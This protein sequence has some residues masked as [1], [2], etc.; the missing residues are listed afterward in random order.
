MT[1]SS[2]FLRRSAL[3]ALLSMGVVALQPAQA[4]SVWIDAQNEAVR[5]IAAAEVITDR[6]I[7][8]YRSGA[9]ADSA[10]A[11]MAVRVAGNRQGV[12]VAL[13]RHTASGARVMRLNRVLR[14]TELEA[15]AR[16]LR[17][18]DSGIEYAEPDVLLK[19]A[20]TPNDPQWVQQWHLGTE[21]AGI[22]VATAWDKAQGSGVTVAV[23]D[24]GVRPHAD[25]AA[26]LLPGY[27]FVTDLKMAGDGN[28]RDADATD[29]GDFTAAGQCGSGVAAESSSWHGTHVAGIVGART[30]N[31]VGVAG[32]APLIRVLPVR[33]LGRC[34]GYTSDIA[35][36]IIWAVGGSVPGAPINANPARVI[37][38]SLGGPGTCALTTQNA[39][40]TARSKGAVVVVAAG[41]SR[42][43]AT[44]TQPANCSGVITVAATN[45]AGGRASYSNFGTKVT[46][47]APGG[48]SDGQ[49]LS[50]YNTGSTTPGTDSYAGLSGTSMAAPVVSGVVA[51]MLSANKA[52]TPDQVAS[53]LKS[54]SRAFP[55]PCSGCGAGLVDATAAVAAAFGQS[56]APAPASTPTP[57]PAP[58]PTPA[59]APAP[60]P[61]TGTVTEKESN[62]TV[63]TAQVLPDG[64]KLVNGSLSTTSDVDHFRFTVPAGKTVAFKLTAGSRS[65]FG[66]GLYLSSGQLLSQVSA[67]VG[68]VS[69]LS[70]RNAG[71][72]PLAIVV[73]VRRTAGEA[74]AY[75]LALQ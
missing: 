57:A 48:D 10:R 61:T 43:D 5:P 36:A 63:A 2:T 19:A 72:A 11:Q 44:G 49:I 39:I 30:G 74:G 9:N 53:L 8:K 34:G 46:L 32:V 38:L 27:D 3:A 52:L 58:A 68:Q 14:G 41:N 7:V 29:P 42:V 65:G 25:L 16:S 1:G 4:A 56:A 37:N 59:P 66:L 70:V 15:M 18:G 17:D 73:S 35:D 13:H 45:K 31:Q 20:W 6:L 12:E 69:T 55:A 64:T 22:R 51:L 21:G 33:A 26:Q 75:T 54:S 71:A 60:A 23:V 40:Q 67:V 47:A 28:G 24:S 62:N 50:T